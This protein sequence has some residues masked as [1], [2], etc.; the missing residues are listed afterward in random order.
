M[1][2]ALATPHVPALSSILAIQDN[3]A[4][5]YCALALPKIGS[6]ATVCT[7]VDITVP[8]L[9]AT[10]ASQLVAVM[11]LAPTMFCTMIAGIA[12]NVAR[13]MRRQ[14]ARIDVEAGSDFV[15][16]HDRYRLAFIKV[17]DLVRGSWRG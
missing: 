17:R 6:N 10:L 13:E 14:H 15:T 11:P 5:S 3:L 4:G 8:S 1:P 12:R 16:D 2:D 9:G 7:K